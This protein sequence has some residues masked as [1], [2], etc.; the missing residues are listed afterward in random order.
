MFGVTGLAIKTSSPLK[1]TFTIELANGYDGYLPPPD[2]HELGGYTT[3]R[4]RSSCLEVQAEPQVR[5]AVVGLLSKVAVPR[6]NE[7][8]VTA[9]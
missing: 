7:S 9:K 1:P 8:V 2:Q 4:A 3:W 5:A 6:A